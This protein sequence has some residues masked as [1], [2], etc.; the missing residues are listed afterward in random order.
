MISQINRP[1]LLLDLS[2]VR[3]NLRKMVDKAHQ[4]GVR[5]RPHFKTHQSVEIGNMA[6]SMG[7]DAITVSSLKMAEFFNHNGWDD[8]TV[9]FPVNLREITEINR[10]AKQA[11]LQLI[12][13]DPYVA[14]RLEAKLQEQVRVWIEVDLGDKRSGIWYEHQD[15]ILELA[16]YL[17]N[18]SDNLVLMGLLSHTGYAY[19]ARSKAEILDIH[20]E[21]TQRIKALKEMLEAAGLG[22]IAISMGD[23]PTSSVAED[24][25]HLDEIRPGNFFFY[26]LMQHQIGACE[27]SDIAVLMVCPVVAVEP[28]KG[29]MIIHG[30]AVH[31][32]KERLTGPDGNPYY[33]KLVP[34]LESGWG[35]SIDATIT[36]LSQEHGV[37]KA[38]PEIL[39]QYLP[40]DL[41]GILPVHSCLTANLMRGY[42]SLDGQLI[43]GMT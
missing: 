10:L 32:S 18:E 23:T 42:M 13:E 21:S 31:F 16:R 27:E 12:L 20:L 3:N 24:F 34:L 37:I 30:G 33:G 29:Q 15:K 28:D 11:R 35:P 19:G 22:E 8:I 25:E 36:S 17:R 9:A 5:L 43:F 40:G 41:V 4:T 14:A 39:N 1:T 2:R 6:R 26:D 38:S 7:I